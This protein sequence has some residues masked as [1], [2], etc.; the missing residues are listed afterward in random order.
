MLRLGLRQLDLTLGLGIR[1]LDLKGENR[2]T[3]HT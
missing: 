3:V 2:Q 1:H